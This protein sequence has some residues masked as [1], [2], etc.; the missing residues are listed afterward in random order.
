MFRRVLIY[1]SDV[2]VK[3]LKYPPSATE[4]DTPLYFEDA[5]LIP[6]DL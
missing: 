3:V 1:G 4:Y 2:N 5:V 6:Y